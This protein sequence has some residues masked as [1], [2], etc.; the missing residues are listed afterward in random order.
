MDPVGLVNARGGLKSSIPKH[1]LG[2]VTCGLLRTGNIHEPGTGFPLGDF[3]P[4]PAVGPRSE[5]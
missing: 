4:I 3:E 2:V 5:A 1:Q